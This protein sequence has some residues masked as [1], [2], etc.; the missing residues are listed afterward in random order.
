MNIRFE[1]KLKLIEYILPK[2]I[3]DNKINKC[4]TIPIKIKNFQHKKSSKNK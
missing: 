2:C 1:K 4:F 3:P